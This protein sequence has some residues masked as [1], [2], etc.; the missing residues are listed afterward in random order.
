MDK[1]ENFYTSSENISKILADSCK[2]N[3]E[4]GTA[5][6]TYVDQGF[7]IN[8][9]LRDG[10]QSF[11]EEVKALDSCFI[12]VKSTSKPFYLLRGIPNPIAQNFL[13]DKTMQD[14]GFCSTTLSSLVAERF[15]TSE[16][17]DETCCLIHIHI[18]TD[19]EVRLL[20]IYPYTG[21]K[22]FKEREVV[23]PCN[24]TLRVIEDQE[25]LETIASAMG[26]ERV[27]KPNILNLFS[28]DETAKT[29]VDFPIY[30]KSDGQHVII[31]EIV[32]PS[33]GKQSL[34][35]KSKAKDFPGLTKKGQDGK[36]Y[37]ST[38]DSKGRYRWVK[39]VR[40]KY[41]LNNSKMPVH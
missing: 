18:P 3:P 20:P 7:D 11:S 23:L 27:E 19:K 34:K 37:V 39:K 17:S 38:S 41:T 28:S 8:C 5:V 14:K 10:D 13:K 24:T 26:Y 33:G 21:D 15:V 29:K 40:S 6:S 9:C 31:M 32:D 2:T 16:S 36:Y 25:L 35:P 4:T 12:S 1:R 30:K 22:T